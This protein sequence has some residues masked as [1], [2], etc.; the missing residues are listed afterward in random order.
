MWHSIL[1]LQQCAHKGMHA[2]IAMLELAQQVTQSDNDGR[3][4]SARAIL[5]N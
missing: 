3:T 4:E 1:Y 5:L 2:H